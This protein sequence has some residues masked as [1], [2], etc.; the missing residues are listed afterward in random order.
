MTTY[1][2]Q[3]NPANPERL[4]WEETCRRFPDRWVVFVDATWPPDNQVDFA[5][6][7]V[8]AHHGKRRDASPDVK[9]A[10]ARGLEP[11]CFWTGEIRSPFPRFFLP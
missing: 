3:L 2:A 8:I 6:A 4:T 5:S 1:A 9:A 11:G 7:V 10:R